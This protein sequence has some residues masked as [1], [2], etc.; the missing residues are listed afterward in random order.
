MLRS[1]LRRWRSPLAL[2]LVA[3]ALSVPVAATP[4]AAADPCA[5][6]VNPVACEN[7]KPG[8]PAATWDVSGSGSTAIQGFATEMSVNAGET[9]RFKV[10]TTASSYRLDIY[11]MGYYGGNGARAIT[12]L[13]VSGK[14]TQPNCL[15]ESSTGLVDCGNWA[16]SASWAVPADAV[17]GIY[18]ARL[19]RTDGTSGASHVFFV[20]RNDASRSDL[21]FQT[22]DTTWQAYNTYGG[23]S[24]YV[25]S[26]AGR[27]YKVSYNRPFTTRGTGAEDFVFNAEYPMV[28][29]LEANGYD[30]SYQAGADTDRRGALLRNHRVFL[31]VGHDEYWSGGQR[32]SVE[33]ARAAGVHLA[34]FS[35]NEMFWKTRWETSKDGSATGYRTLVCYKETHANAIIDPTSEWTGTWRDPRFS[36]PK[37]GGRP[38]NAVTGTMFK[39]NTGTVNLQ[40]PAADGK[41]RLWRNTSVATLAAGA[42]A[43]LGTGTVGYEW[44][45]DAANSV[46]PPGLIQLSTTRATGVQILLDYGSTYGSGDATHHLTL[47]RAAGGALVF[48][49]GTVQ[50]SWGLD[51]SHDRGSG[52]AS[53]PM[54][55]ATVNLFADMGAQPATLQSGLVAAAASTDTAGPSTTITAPANGTSVAAGTTVTVSGT[56]AD[57]GGGVVGGVEVST[58]G[59]TWHPATGRGSWTYSFVP[60]TAGTTQI[61]ARAID[62]SANAG[63]PATV[64]VTVAPRSCPCS[65]W[66]NAD[67]PAVPTDPDTSATEVGVKF[68]ADVAGRITALRFYKGSGNTGTHVGRLWTASGTQLATVT[69]QNETATGW[70]Q[71][72][73]STPVTLTPGATYVASYYAPN[74]RYAGDPGYFATAG[75]DSGPLHA[76]RDGLDGPNGVYRFGSGFPT[77]AWQ[78][79]NYWVDVVFSPSDTAPDTTAPTVTSRTPAAGATGVATGTTVSATF[80]EPV[81]SGSAAVTLTGPAGAVAGSVAYDATAARVTFT[82]A[83]ALATATTYTATVS[84][85]RDAAGN[86]MTSTSWTFT[87]AAAAPPPPSSSCPCSIWPASAVPGTAAD[88]DTAAVEVGLKFRAD[89]TG[90]I[91]GVRFYKGSGNTGTHVGHLWTRDG[92]LLGTVTFGTETATGW[93]QASFSTPVQVSAGTTYVVSYYAPSGRYAGDSGYFAT[94]VDTPPLHALANGVDGANGVYRYGTGGG[95]PTDTW[96]STNYWVDVV[97][98]P[99]A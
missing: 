69:F 77:L 53:T 61:Q 70:Q 5:P 4:A 23:N 52:A 38:E 57:T 18:F 41:M 84:G 88:P 55:Q 21:V 98:I 10:R 92:Q 44:D 2:A 59:A 24:L 29:F 93:Q 34:F 43:T 26:P 22:S 45:E 64:A 47:Y 15:T 89:V 20:V 86:T 78:S 11:R 32:A 95:F 6:L 13:T 99:N 3:A 16:V 97:F 60:T 75:V 35:G 66:T 37:D 31:S 54:R 27:A 51:S 65:L 58:D 42:T 9:Q 73:L 85:A 87:T 50:W 46:R 12:S 17:S 76:L 63:T 96:Q 48:G 62:D 94:G 71:A 56:A 49:A 1:H 67:V 28:R 72:S 19:A 30:V 39:V 82:P 83:T 80:S 81:V 40:V 36:P 25:G 90:Q 14:Q 7:S 33:A 8:T 68:R 79:A 91:T 74:G